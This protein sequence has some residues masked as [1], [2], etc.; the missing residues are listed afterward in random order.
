MTAA[1]NDYRPNMVVIHLGTNDINTETSTPVAPYSSGSGFAETQTGQMATLVDYILKW[2]NGEFGTDLEK[3]IVSQL[4]P[5]DAA[6]DSSV[7]KFN[8]ENNRMVRDFNNGTITGQNEP[9]YLGDPYTRFRENPDIWTHTGLDPMEDEL[10]PNTLGHTIMGNVYY[11]T[12]SQLLGKPPKWF[13]DKTWESGLDGLDYHFG[14]QGVT[15]ADI[16]Q[17]ETDDIYITRSA[18]ASPESR[19]VF[20]NASSSLPLVETAENISIED[21]GESMSAVF[22]D[23][24][25]DGDLDLFNANKNSRNRLYKNNGAGTF[26]E[27]TVQAGIGNIS[28]LTTA[29]L[30]FDCENDGDMDLFAL[31]S[32]AKNEFYLNNGTGQFTK[33]DCGLDDVLEPDIPNSSAIAADFDQDGDVDVYVLKRYAP[34]K[35]FINNGSGL[36]TDQAA[37]AGIALNHK[38]NGGNWA[39]LDTDGDLDL[40]VSVSSTD[41]DPNPHVYAYKNNGNGTFQNISNDLNIPMD[42][43]SVLTG[44]IDNDG[45]IDI[46][47]TQKK[48]TGAVYLNQGNWQF[49][50]AQDTGAEVFAGDTRGAVFW[51]YENDGDLDIVMARKD[52]F[53]IF[54]Q[55]NLSSQNNYLKVNCNGPGGIKGGYGTKIWLYEKGKANDINYLIGFNEIN[56]AAGY[57]SHNSA[58]QHFGLGSHSSCDLVAAFTDGTKILSPSVTSN[59]TVLITPEVNCVHVKTRIYLQGCYAGN[60]IMLK[61]N[62]PPSS[63]TLYSRPGL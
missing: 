52:I 4:I 35:L 25:G 34:N 43:Y 37:S 33:T 47:T 21:N 60:G 3:I 57:L 1:M 22:V 62:V 39:D 18:P 48:N 15:L 27:I 63:N 28:S 38:S 61:N 44:D 58:T 49:S 36:F 56:T 8:I 11:E 14:F 45:K 6:R 26:T 50:K 53:N 19:D 10:H 24:D 59:Q 13:N 16:T 7:A 20:Y 54:K 30:A 32:R 55:N 5:L 29:V 51:D 31:N 42:G 23:I 41:S 40:L 46:I 12:S 9:V 17:N 2:N